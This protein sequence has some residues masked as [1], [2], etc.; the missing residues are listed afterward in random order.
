MID[1]ALKLKKE[2]C[3]GFIG[4]RDRVLFEETV[5]ENGK[6]YLY[7]H[8]ERYVKV[9]ILENEAIEKGLKSNSIKEIEIQHIIYN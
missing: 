6:T 3:N 5:V 2:Y 8:N 7:G 9:G 1:D 4:K